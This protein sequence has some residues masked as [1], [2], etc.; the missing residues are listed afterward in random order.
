[1]LADLFAH[2]SAVALEYARRIDQLE[3][4]VTSRQL[5][6]PAVGMVMERFQVDDVRAVGF[7]TRLS[8]QENLELRL[9]A[10]RLLAAH[11]DS[12]GM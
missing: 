2:Q 1:M 6:G 10:Q 12:P 7:L 8:C 5:V 11:R 4:A 9:V 3:E